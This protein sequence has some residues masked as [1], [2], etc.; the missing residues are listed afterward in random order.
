MGVHRPL[1]RG[2][3]P[4]PH[5]LEELQAGE[6][7]AR[8]LDEE[9]QEVE[10]EG[11]EVHG[12]PVDPRLPPVEVHPDPRGLDDPRLPRL[13]LCPA[14]DGPDPGLELS[15]AE[16]LHD[17]VVGPEL[18][19]Q[20]PV[21]LR[22]PGGEHDDGDLGLL[23]DLPGNF[24]SVHPRQHEVEEDEVGG[25]ALNSAKASG[26]DAAVV[27]ANPARSRYPRTSLRTHPSSST[28]RIRFISPKV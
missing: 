21:V 4:A 1:K 25:W 15:G 19:P 5:R 28:R 22:G 13:P 11:G 18:Q 9:R 7:P 12:L 14:E 8:V 10:L 26:P 24:E 23:A 20:D 2:E 27:T 3:R 17:V 6:R 16:R